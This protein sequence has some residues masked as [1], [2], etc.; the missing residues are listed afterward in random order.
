MDFE[1]IKQSSHKP[2][3]I[4]IIFA[5]ALQQNYTEIEIEVGPNQTLNYKLNTDESLKL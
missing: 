1:T 3:I 4:N 2:I 5:C